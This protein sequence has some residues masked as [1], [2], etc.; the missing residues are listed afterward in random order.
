LELPV[1]NPRRQDPPADPL[2]ALVQRMAARDEQ[3]LMKLYDA[4]SSR[5]Y[6]LAVKIL[7]D[8]AAAEEVTL[9]VFHQAWHGAAGFDP[10]RAGVSTWLL[11]IARSRAIDRVRSRD[12]GRV[13]ERPLSD[14]ASTMDPR[15]DP[16]QHAIAADRAERVRRAMA[17]LRPEQRDVLELAFYGGLSHGQI[18]AR[19]GLPLGTVKTRIRAGIRRLTDSLAEK[20]S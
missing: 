9:D 4:T 12:L 11:T 10:R 5:V 2:G 17:A 14:G 6:G 18:A 13:R 20:E 16:E 8:A 1:P 15:P 7:A 19:L 3:A